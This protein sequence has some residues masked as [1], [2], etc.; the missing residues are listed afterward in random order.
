MDYIRVGTMN[1]KDDKINR[2]G[3]IREDGT[4]N[5]KLVS[6]IIKERD[7]DLLG[8]QELTIKYVNELS[9]FLPNY[10]FYGNYRYGNLLTR[11]PYNENNQIITKCNVLESKT[12]W[13]PWLA[14]NFSDLKDSVIK[15]SIMPRIA[16]IV[17]SEDEEHRKVCMIN[18]HLDYQVPSI[19]VRQLK[20][21]KQLIQKYS[22]LYDIILT[23]DFNMQIGDN[24]FDLFVNDIKDK[25]QHV[26]VHGVTWHGTNGEEAQVDHIFIPKNW[27][28]ENAEIIDLKGTSDHDAICVDIKR[29]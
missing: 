10:K 26:D 17:I 19:Q 20:A 11:M 27:K 24:N 1:T 25:L 18:T 2:N 6:C 21:L 3:G 29:R 4:N 23:G 15:M 12:I 5:A 7:F 28:I 9:S 22:Q 16:T 8:T 13:L 14:N